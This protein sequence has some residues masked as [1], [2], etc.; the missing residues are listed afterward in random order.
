MFARTFV[1][2]VM[3][4]SKRFPMRTDVRLVETNSNFGQNLVFAFEQMFA[5]GNVEGSE[6]IKFAAYPPSRRDEALNDFSVEL[7]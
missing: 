3:T 1:R 5:F 7:L 2:L 4:N 6:S